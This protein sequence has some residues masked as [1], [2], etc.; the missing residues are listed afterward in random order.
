MTVQFIDPV[1]DCLIPAKPYGLA[2]DLTKPL[3][4]GLV[5]NRI[6]QCDIFMRHVAEELS[7]A[8]PAVS[9]RFFETGTITFA[10]AALI[11]EIANTCDAAICAIGHCGS[12]TA[13]T[14]KDGINLIE[15]GCPSVCLVTDLFWDQADALAMSLG[16]PGAPRIKLPYPIWGTDQTSMIL[17]AKN[18]VRDLIPKLEVMPN[19]NA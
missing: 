1:A 15:Q 6:P 5:I 9:I 16:W 4:I 18:A 3:N 19:D 13:G 17:S 7:K 14:V 2:A 10:D 11:T 8:R 12:C